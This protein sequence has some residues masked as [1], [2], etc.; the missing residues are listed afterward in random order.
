MII[1]NE[2]Q[3]CQIDELF[4]SENDWIVYLCAFTSYAF[5]TIGEANNRHENLIKIAARAVTALAICNGLNILHILTIVKKESLLIDSVELERKTILRIARSDET[6]YD[7]MIKIAAFAV[8]TIS[9]KVQL[10]GQ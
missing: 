10:K 3:K 9:K 7:I 1:F 8:A 6:F 5:P 2:V 4:D